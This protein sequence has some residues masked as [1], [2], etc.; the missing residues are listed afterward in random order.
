M[1]LTTLEAVDFRLES[2]RTLD[3]GRDWVAFT[4]PNG[5]GKTNWLDAVHFLCLGRS[6]FTRQDRNLV[7]FGQRGF[8]LVGQFGA[9]RPAAG[10][11]GAGRPAAGSDGAG[12]PAAG[13]LQGEPLSAQITVVYKTGGGKEVAVNGRLYDRLSEHLGRFPVV[14]VAPG[15]LVLLEGGATERRRMVDMM[16]AQ[17]SPDYVHVLLRRDH[18]LAQRNALLRAARLGPAPD[19]DLMECYD[20]ELILCHRRIHASRLE[21]IASYGPLV[22]QIYAGMGGTDEIAEVRYLSEWTEQADLGQRP[23]LRREIEAGYTLWGTQRDD[24]DFH[25][26]GRPARRY[27]S[28]GQRKSLVLALKL[29]QVRFFL[30]SGKTY[31]ALLLDDFF[32]KLDHHRLKGLVQVLQDLSARGV[33]VFLS[34]TGTQRV[35]DLLASCGQDCTIFELTKPLPSP[36]SEFHHAPPNP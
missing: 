33:Q 30:Q 12:R 35:R 24:L 26:D 29:A 22:S 2:G 32:E 15:D 17:S 31:A 6:Y 4:G 9:G 7:R 19:K 1:F 10:P 36:C 3:L 11:D 13:P 28:Q 18:F 25:L 16:L 23:D 20:R 21:W 5:S 14:M 27:A 8:R 34:D